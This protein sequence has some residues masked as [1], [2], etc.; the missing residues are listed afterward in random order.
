[1]DDQY[2]AELFQ[3][4]PL[5]DIGKVGMPDAILLKH[6]KLNSEEFDIMKKHVTF[7]VEALSHDLD[8]ESTAK[9]SYSY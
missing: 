6:G 2:I 1:M 5:H 3:T 9:F 7:G 4:A 8:L